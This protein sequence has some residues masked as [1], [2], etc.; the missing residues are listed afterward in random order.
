[1]SERQELARAFE[2]TGNDY[3]RY[4]P[5]FPR[6]A[7]DLLVPAHV[8]SILDLGA[9]TG[10]LTEL[11]IDR[12]DEVFAIDP[13]ASM[14]DV[15]RTKLPSVVALSGTAEDIPLEEG[16]VDMVLVAQAFHW[17]ERDAA[18]RQ[19]RRVLRPGGVLGLVW[20]GS[21]RACAWDV[22]CARIAHPESGTTEAADETA[23]ELPGFT[24]LR[25]QRFAWT[26]RISRTD[27]VRRWHTV[28]TFLAADDATHRRMTAEL[29]VV[30]NTDP[31]TRGRD[32]LELPQS[33]I[34]FVYAAL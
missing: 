32:L 17:F 20:N 31:A 26:E 29:D 16:T 14:L 2:L 11:L 4:R 19:I 15:L 1:M 7:V 6:A 33:T 34:A 27:Y 3:E 24:I 30:L 10:K 9:G 21:D 25:S 22:A 12:A 18:C 5:S 28:S 13:S 23:A 8:R